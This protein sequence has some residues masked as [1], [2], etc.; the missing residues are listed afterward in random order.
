MMNPTKFGSPHLDTPSLKYEFF[1]LTFKSM[2]NKKNQYNTV[3]ERWGPL[4][5]GP[6]R[7]R[8]R[9]EV[10]FRLAKSRRR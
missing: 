1:K 10:A 7:Q 9:T 3:I 5:N 6:T 8:Q 2:K 4:V